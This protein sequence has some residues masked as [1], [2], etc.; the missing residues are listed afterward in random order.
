MKTFVLI[1]RI[2]WGDVAPV[3]D[4][5]EEKILEACD[6]HYAEVSQCEEAQARIK[7]IKHKDGVIRTYCSPSG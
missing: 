6:K 4:A 1:C 5:Q 2:F 7:T 3:Y